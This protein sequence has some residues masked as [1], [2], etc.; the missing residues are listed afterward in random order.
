MN[1]FKKAQKDN[2]KDQKKVKKIRD[3]FRKKH[4]YY[5]TGAKAKVEAE[6]KE[7]EEKVKKASKKKQIGRKNLDELLTLG[8]LSGKIEKER[9]KLV[10]GEW[11]MVPVTYLIGELYKKGLRDFKGTPLEG[12][13]GRFGIGST[14]DDWT[15][16][17]QLKGDKMVNV[18]RLNLSR[19]HEQALTSFNKPSEATDREM[20]IDDVFNPKKKKEAMEY[21]EERGGGDGSGGKSF[22]VKGIKHLRDVNLSK[23][24]WAFKLGMTAS[25]INKNSPRV[26]RN[27]IQASAFKSNLPWAKDGETL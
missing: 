19:L 8:D 4:D 27:S 24:K 18:F 17:Y 9:K 20:L 23:D 25:D 14:R 21:L 22:D 10:T 6:A 2:Q 7:M 1:A 5:A 15:V 13:G 16:V 11:Y 3:A 26:G 12:D